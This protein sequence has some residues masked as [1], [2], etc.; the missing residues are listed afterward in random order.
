MKAL[1]YKKELR[2]TDIPNPAPAADEALIKT[3]TAGICATDLEIFKG[4]MNFE[5]IPGHEFAGEVIEAA[6]AALIGKRV[7][8]EINA[9]CGKCNYCLTGLER[10]CPNRTTL[11]IKGRN[12]VFAEYFTLPMKNLYPIP[13]NLSSHEAVF[14][15]PLAAA[16][17]IMEQ[18]HINPNWKVLLIGDGRLAALIAQVLKLHGLDFITA[19]KNS[20]KLSLFNE[21]GS[22]TIET[23]PPKAGYDLV[24]EASG[25]PSGWDSA[26]SAVKPRGTIVLK[27]TYA[28]SFNFNPAPLVINEI[29]VTGSRCGKFAPAI[30]LLEAGLVDVEKLISAVYPFD[31]ILEAV[32]YAKKPD[33]FK[34]LVDFS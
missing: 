24:I 21:W 26:V 30:R 2:F 28:G 8:G 18:V 22:H 31:R 7:A 9:G 27:S 17:E 19:G 13:E 11:G 12:G 15:E 14:V 3:I 20:K 34:V 33:V 4:Y 5:G 29:T 23:D 10:H 32:E 6:E 1:L 25:H 16:V